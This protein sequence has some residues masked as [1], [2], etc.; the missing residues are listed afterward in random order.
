MG[1]RQKLIGNAPLAYSSLVEYLVGAGAVRARPFDA[2]ACPDATLN[3]LS[4][5]KVRAFLSR[6]Q[7]ERNYPIGP[8]TLTGTALTHLNLLDH[9]RPSHAAILLFGKQPQRFLMTSEVK[10]L[11]FHGVAVA[12]PIPDYRIHN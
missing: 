8:R 12:K 7:T 4:R 1:S 5:E 3:D 2:A 10:C 6:A 9:G 11:Q